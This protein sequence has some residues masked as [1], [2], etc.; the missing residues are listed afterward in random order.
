MKKD[1][2]FERSLEYIS[3][4]GQISLPTTAFGKTA[5]TSE[6]NFEYI[7]RDGQITVPTIAFGKKTGRAIIQRVPLQ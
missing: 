5:R 2:R 7:S 3:R 6:V 1:S 4:D